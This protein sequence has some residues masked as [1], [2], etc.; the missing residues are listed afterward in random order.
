MN[1]STIT[2]DPVEAQ[3]KLDA[4]RDALAARHS[5]KVEEEWQAA[6][7][8]YKELAKGTPLID[9]LAAIRECGWRSDS[10][11]VLAIARADM[12]R[13]A[14]DVSRSSRWW[15]PDARRHKGAWA[16]MQWQFAAQRNHESNWRWREGAGKSFVIPNITAEPPGDPASGIAMVPMVPPDVLPARGC[17]LSKHYILWEVESWDVSP[18]VDPILLRPIGGDL[19]AV[20]AQWDLTEIE[21]TIIAGTRKA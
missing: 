13:V 8:A 9:P 18:P 5:V 20:V 4:Y 17:D 3:Q 10:R 15:D 11:P 7:D 2:M 21:R 1:V 14:W 6:A 19:Y 16:P 12:A